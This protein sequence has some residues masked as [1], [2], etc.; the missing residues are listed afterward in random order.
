MIEVSLE[1]AQ[2]FILE[3][4]G[5]LTNSPSKSILEVAKRI[6]NIQ[7]DTISVVARSHDLTVFNRLKQ[8]KE[9]EIWE[10]QKQKRLFEAYSHA[11]CMM[12][13]EDYPFYN[14][15]TSYYHENEKP[16]WWSSWIN[17]NK[18]VIDFV[19]NSIKKQ[20]AL[21]SKDFKVPQER[22]SKGW[23]NWKKEKRALEH[24]FYCGK[25]MIA[26]RSGFQKFYDLAERVLPSDIEQEPMNL[27]EIPDYLLR[28][29]FSAYGIGNF[30]EMKSYISSK[31]SKL[32]WN[33]KQERITSFLE[34][35]A[36]EGILERVQINSIKETHYVLNDDID[37]L[38]KC[39]EIVVDSMKLLN[40]FDN[41][42][43]DRP[44]FLKY[45][46]FDY[47]LE[48]YTPPVQ[49]KYGYYLMPIL[50]GHLFIGRLEPK[51]HRKESILEIKS[52]YYEDWFKPT[53][54]SNKRLALS[55]SKF[56]DFHKCCKIRLE[57]SI[58]TEIRKSLSSTI[59]ST[60]LA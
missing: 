58:P 59:D 52:I 8:Y 50:D 38:T 3:K 29:I 40:P 6:H 36:N 14:W 49:R 11:L 57:K 7:I 15:K 25:L 43:R 26:Y 22:K 23:W 19:Y 2:K 18:D 13:I 46:N 4:Q 21:S 45:W 53:K 35:K 28:K 56:A 10:L 42:I 30:V 27:D 55:L 34:D 24:L 31:A 5:L 54:E 48:A 20:G 1:Q 16:T 9:K 17:D 44:V 39:N 32:L 37:N 41:V 12:P 47:K 33:N 60:Y 51:A